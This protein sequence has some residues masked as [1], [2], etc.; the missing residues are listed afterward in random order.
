MYDYELVPDLLDFADHFSSDSGQNKVLYNQLL[1]KYGNLVVPVGLAFLVDRVRQFSFSTIFTYSAN[2]IRGN[3]LIMEYGVKY[4]MLLQSIFS[5]LSGNGYTKLLESLYEK[6]EAVASIA[7]IEIAIMELAQP[8]AIPQ[9]EKIFGR[10]KSSGLKFATAAA[11]A[12][13]GRRTYLDKMLSK[14][15]VIKKDFYI[16]LDMMS[17]Q[18]KKEDANSIYY[19]YAIDGSVKL[20]I[21]N[22]GTKGMGPKDV[23]RDWIE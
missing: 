21:F 22:V 18:M 8:D 20:V 14:F 10:A 19:Q 12:I 1:K 15:P 13:L 17:A 11:L 6:D 9:L 23:Y 3:E 2:E 4:L 16:Y 5:N 7:A